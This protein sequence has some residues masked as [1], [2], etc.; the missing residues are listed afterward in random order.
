V[1]QRQALG[2]LPSARVCAR[3]P[4]SFHP[5]WSSKLGSQTQS[6]RHG[7]AHTGARLPG[8]LDTNDG[9]AERRLRGCPRHSLSVLVGR[10]PVAQIVKVNRSKVDGVG[11]FYDAVVPQVAFCRQAWRR[12]G[13][14]S[15]GRRSD[16]SRAGG[17]A[18]AHAASSLGAWRWAR[19]CAIP[20]RTNTTQSDHIDPPQPPAVLTVGQGIRRFHRRARGRRRRAWA[21]AVDDC[22][23]AERRALPA[24]SLEPGCYGNVRRRHL[25]SAGPGMQRVESRPSA[26]VF[27]SAWALQSRASR[28]VQRPCPPE[29]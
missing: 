27:S 29:S 7:T 24:R 19:P 5:A 2:N 1:R 20:H 8:L 23:E 14:Q 10:A 17:A 9:G 11:P 22:I 21:A 6:A 12:A 26:A 3:G 28:G 15:G 18:T 13:E 25:P 4:R 16:G